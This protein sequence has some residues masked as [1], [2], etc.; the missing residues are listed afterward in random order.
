MT[1]NQKPKYSDLSSVTKWKMNI[2]KTFAANF[3]V[4]YPLPITHLH[5]EFCLNPYQTNQVLTSLIELDVKHIWNERRHAK[6]LHISMRYR[7]FICVTCNNIN[8]IAA[9]TFTFC[10]LAYFG[11]NQKHTTRLE[12]AFVS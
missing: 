11:K 1:I 5:Y 10:W 12:T 7:T 4:F 3:R 2:L 6:S 8:F 9:Q